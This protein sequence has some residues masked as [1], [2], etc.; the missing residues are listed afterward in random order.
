VSFLGLVAVGAGSAENKSDLALYFLNMSKDISNIDASMGLLNNAT[1]NFSLYC[2]ERSLELDNNL[3]EARLR[4]YN[5]LMQS[6]RYEEVISFCDKLLEEGPLQQDIWYWK[7]QALDKLARGSEAIECYDRAICCYSLLQGASYSDKQREGDAWFYKAQGHE[8]MKENTKALSCYIKSIEIYSNLTYYVERSRLATPWQEMG[9]VLLEM[10]R[11]NESITC[12][13]KVISKMD[14][15]S[16]LAANAS[17]GMGLAQLLLANNLRRKGR[18]PSACYE[19]SN[20]SYGNAIQALEYNNEKK[21]AWSAYFGKGVALSFLPGKG[22]DSRAAFNKAA[23]LAR[24]NEIPY[25]KWIANSLQWIFE[26]AK[27]A[28]DYAK[29]RTA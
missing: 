17:K 20:I 14:K 15:S 21:L 27:G 19:Q 12:F 25:L 28:L 26:K 8:R 2:V 9:F 23:Q 24:G 10:G 18:D 4:K 16:L 22:E 11:Y 3:H 5:L 29:S 1:L 13:K 7:A 6:G